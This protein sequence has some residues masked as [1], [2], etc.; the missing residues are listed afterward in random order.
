[1]KKYESKKLRLK[2]KEG[3]L[4]RNPRT[5]ERLKPNMVHTM[6]ATLYWLRRVKQGDCTI[7]GKNEPKVT[8]PEP[9]ADKPKQKG[10]VKKQDNEKLGE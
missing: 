3:S 7:A 6:P 1:M 2:V 5:G 8:Q 10:S 9:K 4:I